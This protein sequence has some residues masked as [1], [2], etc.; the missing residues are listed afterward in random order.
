MTVA[1]LSHPIGERD[2]GW[3][4]DR[5]DNLANA[6]DWFRFLKDVT[7]WAICFP[8]MAYIAAVDDAFHRPSMITDAV[9]IMERCDV[10]IVAGA[11]SPHIRIE[12]AHARGRRP[13]I[14]VLDLTDLGRRP[15][16]PAQSDEL[17]VEVRRRAEALGL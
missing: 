5:G 6:M 3:G 7:R 12:I 11:Y 8:S 4:S 10:L 17:G 9:E 2:A 14:P 16:P 13:P 1:F 15:P